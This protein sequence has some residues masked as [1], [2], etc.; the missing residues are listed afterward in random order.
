MANGGGEIRGQILPQITATPFTAVLSGD[1]EKPNPVT[2]T[3]A[4]T[5]MFLLEGKVL[6]FSLRYSGLPSAATAAHVH[7]PADSTQSVGVLI[8]LAPYVD[9]A[10]GTAGAIA[11]SLILTDQQKLDVLAGRTYVNIHT[12]GTYGGGEIRGFLAPIPEPETY[13]L[14]LAGLGAVAWAARKRSV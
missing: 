4:G 6:N 12:P 14:M 5:A 2:T 11:G 8:S 9:G 7:G 10:F 1:A 3:G 13:A